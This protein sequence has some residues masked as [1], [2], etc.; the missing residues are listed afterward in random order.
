MLKCL[1]S[2]IG[3]VVFLI[4]AWQ[5]RDLMFEIILSYNKFF[6]GTT[7]GL[8]L[9]VLSLPILEIITSH[10]VCRSWR[11]RLRRQDDISRSLSWWKKP[12]RYFQYINTALYPI[13]S[14]GVGRV[15][16][17]L[18]EDAGFGNRAYTI[19]ICMIS[20]IGFGILL[21]F[22]LKERILL[23]GF[24]LFLLLI[25]I[26]TLIYSRARNRRRLF[27][28][29][30]PDLLDRLVDCLQAGFSFPQAV[31]FIAPNL[32]NPS[33]SEMKHIAGQIST[34]LSVEQALRDLHS[35]CPSEDVR[36]FVEGVILQRQVGGNMTSMMLEMADIVRNR[37][38]LENQ[39]RTKSAQGRLSAI[40]LAL[41]VPVSL[42]LLSTFQ[43]YTDSL[44]N[45]VIGNFVLIIAGTLELIG[46]VIVS[47]LI[48]IE[49]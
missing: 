48:R 26:G 2:I 8:F 41:M 21:F 12:K 23:W 3:Y 6:I 43:G 1:T 9:L 42:I 37:I 14:R 46:A 7:A 32:S 17:R 28:D 45:T 10:E 4:I 19:V 16:L 35:R 24:I 47:R 5:F 18:L 44:F 36:L 22:F 34:G 39:V 49:V 38:E 13:F 31:D 20:F 11:Q 29:Q 30:L 15:L 25:G 40:V 27:Q 33:A